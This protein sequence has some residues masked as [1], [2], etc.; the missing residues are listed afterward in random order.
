MCKGIKMKFISIAF[1]LLFFHS[2]F[3]HEHNLEQATE[4]KAPLSGE[5]VFN[6]KS[7]WTTQDGKVVGIDFLR[8]HPSV[9]V[10]A[11]TTCQAS[12]PLLVQDMKRIETALKSGAQQVTFALF[13]F[14]SKR[15]TPEQLKR[16]A[17]EHKLEMKNWVLLHG[18]SNA[19]RDLA[20]ALDVRY[21]QDVSG[22][23]SHSNVVTL[24]DS[25]G[26]IRVQQTGIGGKEIETKLGEIEAQN[27]R[28][29][30]AQ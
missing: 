17:K 12:C 21:K 3:A 4:R 14:D 29:H 26:V 6:L 18:D 30:A 20:A 15:D 23:F 13:S 9:V 5:S 11:Y 28:T 7:K 8:T 10:M 22:E 2:A 25:E 24:L 27:M 1:L 19:V 16:Y